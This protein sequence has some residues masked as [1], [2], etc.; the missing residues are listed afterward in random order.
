VE[1]LFPVLVGL[2][3]CMVSKPHEIPFR[4]AAEESGVD[5]GG[6]VSIGDRYEIDLALP[7]EMGMGGVLVD[8][9]EDV[10]R[11]PRILEADSAA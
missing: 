7:L 2:D 11:L 5:T 10:Y 3:T 4:K 1:D 8:G 6:C 9:V